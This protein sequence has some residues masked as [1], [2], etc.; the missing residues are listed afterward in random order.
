MKLTNEVIV[1]LNELLNKYDNKYADLD[2]FYEAVNII[3]R[4]SFF[5]NLIK[6]EIDFNIPNIAVKNFNPLIVINLDG[7]K[8]NILYLLS[9]FKDKMTSKTYI[10]FYN[11]FF[12]SQIFHEVVHIE[13]GM[14]ALDEKSEYEYLIYIYRIIITYFKKMDWFKRKLYEKKGIYYSFERCANIVSFREILKLEMNEY[15]K[16]LIKYFYL[17][18]FSLGY[19]NKKNR[20]LSPIENTFKWIGAHDKVGESEL[21]FDL[22]IEHGL[23][24]TKDDYN[25]FYGLFLGKSLSEI[26]YDEVMLKLNWK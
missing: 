5:D 12:L 8:E 24:I 7:V 1:E 19:I 23:P 11:L 14:I 20:I 25:D 13:Q 26:N 6:T 4:L 16:N 15:Q 2:F 18:N 21:P 3:N 22:I 9:D 10:N 17:A